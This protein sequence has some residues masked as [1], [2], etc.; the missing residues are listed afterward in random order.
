MKSANLAANPPKP[1]EGG[2]PSAI[3]TSLFDA[4]KDLF[5]WLRLSAWNRVFDG[6]DRTHGTE[7]S[8]D[9]SLKRLGILRP[10]ARFGVR[11]QPIE[12]GVFRSALRALPSKIAPGEFSFIDLGCGKGRAL[13]LA[14]E[15]Y[16]REILGVDLSPVLVE[17]ARRNL[18]QTHTANARVVCQNAA[19]FRFPPGNLVVYLFN[20]F[21]GP[22]FRHAMENLCRSATGRVWLVYINPVEKA[23]LE[24]KRCFVSWK[25]SA[26]FAIYQHHPHSRT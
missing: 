17:C 23:A 19:A 20:P 12:P 22:V 7:T 16:F 25:S 4:G 13:I 11:Y 15:F 6:F 26:T 3:P 10:L 1:S 8:G 24:E 21:W 18:A 14:R 2:S 5:F 9:I